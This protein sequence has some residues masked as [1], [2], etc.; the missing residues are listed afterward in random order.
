M[1]LWWRG[2]VVQMRGAM[3]GSLVADAMTLGTHYEYDA[4][5]IKQYYGSLD[6]YYAPGQKTGG[7]THGVGWGARNFHNG[8]QRGPPKAAG[9]QVK[10]ACVDRVTLH[11]LHLSPTTNVALPWW[12]CWV[13]RQR[14][15]L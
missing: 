14:R 11:R 5:K 15:V 9:E 4:K 12:L 13:A 1:V 8:N 10:A 2:G 3:L 7:Q 6:T